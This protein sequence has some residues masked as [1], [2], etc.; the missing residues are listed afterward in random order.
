MEASGRFKAAV[1]FCSGRYI[2]V[3]DDDDAYEPD[4]VARLVAA[5]ERDPAAGVA[6]CRYV[7]DVDGELYATPAG[8]RAGRLPD[9]AQALISARVSVGS[10]Q[11]LIRREALDAAE[12]W[13]PMPDGV[14]PDRYV[15][16]HAGLTGW[17]H[18][19]VDEVLVRRRWHPQQMTRAGCDSLERTLATALSLRI[20]DPDL[21]HVRRRRVAEL[22]VARALCDL[23]AGDHRAARASLRE[24]ARADRRAARRRRAAAWL[25]ASPGAGVLLGPAYRLSDRLERAP[26]LPPGA[27]GGRAERAPR[28]Q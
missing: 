26:E 10:S 25:I 5:L 28:W 18:V 22:L 3:L 2:G 6:F 11:M 1:A 7:W 12:S 15:N 9:S 21:E 23:R 19:V 17:H 20:D 16:V 14:A 13:Q 27:V 4:F 8:P 24:A